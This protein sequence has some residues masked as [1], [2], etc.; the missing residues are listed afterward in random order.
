MHLR[1]EIESVAS[2]VSSTMTGCNPSESRTSSLWW[3][4]HN[5]SIARLLESVATCAGAERASGLDITIFTQNKL[6]SITVDHETVDDSGRS[7]F[8]VIK[9]KSKFKRRRRWR[10]C[11][12]DYIR[13]LSMLVYRM[14]GTKSDFLWTLRLSIRSLQQLS[15]RSRKPSLRCQQCACSKKT[16]FLHPCV[17]DSNLPDEKCLGRNPGLD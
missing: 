2:R 15:A 9:G 17:Q 13:S 3:S 10:T 14:S 4:S 7:A 12:L 11:S 1:R 8:L 6:G 16:R 5:V